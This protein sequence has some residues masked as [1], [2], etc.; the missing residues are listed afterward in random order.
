MTSASTIREAINTR[1]F[2]LFTVCISDQRSYLVPHPDFIVVG[3]NGRTVIVFLPDGGASVL[4]PLH[5]TSLDYQ[6]IPEPTTP[7]EH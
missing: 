5:I 2:R 4:D 1:P 6:A 7:G 3:P